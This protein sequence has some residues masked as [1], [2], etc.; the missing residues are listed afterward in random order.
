MKTYIEDN[1]LEADFDHW[2]KASTWTNAETIFLINGIEPSKVLVEEKNYIEE[3]LKCQ[4]SEFIRVDKHQKLIERA[5]I[6][7][8]LERRNHPIIAM[9][10]C[11]DV[12]LEVPLELKELVIAQFERQQKRADELQGK[13]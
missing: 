3:G 7:G 2:S 5:R 11:D 10:W 6:D 4:I 12:G 1:N 9:T 13:Q 8:R